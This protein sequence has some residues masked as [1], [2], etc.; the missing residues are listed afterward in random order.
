MAGRIQTLAVAVVEQYDGDA[1]ALWEGA[2]SGAELFRR[3]RALPGYGE[4]KAKIFVA[5]LGKQRGMQ[6]DGWESAAGAYAEPGSYRSV[7]DVVDAASLAK[8]RAFKQEQKRS[9]K[10]A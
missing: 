3:L 9:A 5:L 7:A 8:V 10:G 6:P 4:T 2:S 1:A